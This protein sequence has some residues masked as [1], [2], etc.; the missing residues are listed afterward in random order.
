MIPLGCG[1][2]MILTLGIPNPTNKLQVTSNYIFGNEKIVNFVNSVS[3]FS[4]VNGHQPRK[5]KVRLFA[6]ST[7]LFQTGIENFGLFAAI[8]KASEISD[9]FVW[10][11]PICVQLV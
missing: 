1:V 11:N 3:Q 2:Y 9:L 7:L 5:G 4:L 8:F 10:L 6:L